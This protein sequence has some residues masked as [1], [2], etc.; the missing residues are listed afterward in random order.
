MNIHNKLMK[1][2]KKVEL[3]FAENAV[4]KTL[5]QA[6]RKAMEEQY[7]EQDKEIVHEVLGKLMQDCRIEITP[8]RR[9][10]DVSISNKN[11]NEK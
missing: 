10:E 6:I 3:K 7:K 11:K 8:S 5:K 4:E 2:T 1:M 9:I